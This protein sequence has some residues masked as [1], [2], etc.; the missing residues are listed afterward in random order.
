MNLFTYHV[1]LNIPNYCKVLRNTLHIFVT[2]LEICFY[3][4][5]FDRIV[6]FQTALHLL[7]FNDCASQMLKHLVIS[8]SEKERV[9]ENSLV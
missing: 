2:I 9:P 7:H 8:N 5:T 4:I 3:Q 1:G 6:F